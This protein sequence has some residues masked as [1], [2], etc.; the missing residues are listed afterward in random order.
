MMIKIQSKNMYYQLNSTQKLFT[1][2]QYPM[3]IDK[4]DITG[5]QEILSNVGGYWSGISGVGFLLLNYFLFQNFIHSQAKFLY[6]QKISGVQHSDHVHQSMPDDIIRYE[7]GEKTIN[8]S[9]SSSSNDSGSRSAGKNEREE[10]HSTINSSAE[11]KQIDV[12]LEIKQVETEFMQR[13]SFS[14]IFNLYDKVELASNIAKSTLGQ[15]EH[16]MKNIQELNTRCLS[17]EFAVNELQED[18]KKLR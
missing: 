17:L 6:E 9:S 15:S 11:A 8:E 10:S 13:L 2:D 3:L 16:N 14:G 18:N 4:C 1:F 12:E 7:G 5:L